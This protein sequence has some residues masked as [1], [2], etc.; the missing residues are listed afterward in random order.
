M[1]HESRCHLGRLQ[2]VIHVK[3]WFCLWLSLN[4]LKVVSGVS[5]DGI[6][7]AP[8][9]L[10]LL[11]LRPH[12]FIPDFN[13]WLN[14]GVDS[15][16]LYFLIQEDIHPAVKVSGDRLEIGGLH[17][18]SFSAFRRVNE[19]GGKSLVLVVLVDHRFASVHPELRIAHEFLD[20]LVLQN[21]LY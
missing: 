20:V 13:L 16:L 4:S 10:H 1:D 21:R 8:R 18:L 14:Q 9:V 2:V 7:I 5:L 3:S 19:F 12:E 11:S 15:L 17:L 6:Q